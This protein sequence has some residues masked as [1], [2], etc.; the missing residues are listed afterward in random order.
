MAEFLPDEQTAY[1]IEAFI[2]LD[3]KGDGTIRIQLA[4]TTLVHH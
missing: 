4:M 3:K 1:N 2:L